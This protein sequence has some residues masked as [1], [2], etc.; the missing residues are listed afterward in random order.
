MYRTVTK[1]ESEQYE[2]MLNAWW[3]NL[4]HNTKSEFYHL[5]NNYVKEY[6]SPKSL[7][8]TVSKKDFQP[9]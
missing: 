9:V 2:K 8:D 7:N 3:H 1:K 5:L 6:K 4:G